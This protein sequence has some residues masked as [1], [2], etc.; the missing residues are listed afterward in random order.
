MLLGGFKL[1]VTYSKLQEYAKQHGGYDVSVEGEDI[2]LTFVPAF[3]EALEKGDS[4]TPPPRVMMKGKLT[5]G[6]IEFESVEVE[7]KSGI[8]K[9]EMEDAE[10]T[11]RSWLEFIEENY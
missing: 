11:Y 3:P 4:E 8:H 1:R 5:M 7:D 6:K 9:K 10:L 2:V